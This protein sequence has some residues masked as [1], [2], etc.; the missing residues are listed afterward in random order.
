MEKAKEEQ[1]V[2]SKKRYRIA[3]LIKYI[4]L[5]LLVVLLFLP[6]LQFQ[7]S[8]R[9]FSDTQ[10]KSR[11]SVFQFLIG[12]TETNIEILRESD[13]EEVLASVKVDV[14]A[15]IFGDETASLIGRF[16]IMIG[17]GISWGVLSMFVTDSIFIFGKK[18]NPK[19]Q[20]KLD[21]EYI[22][23]EYELLPRAFSFLEKFIM[24]V[25][26]ATHMLFLPFALIPKYTWRCNIFWPALVIV[27]IIFMNECI[28][29]KIICAKDIRAIKQYGARFDE[30]YERPTI[31][32]DMRE[33]GALF[34]G[35][36][37]TAETKEP[38]AIEMLQRYKSLLDSGVITEEEFAEKKKTLLGINEKDSES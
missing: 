12:D 32:S 37:T 30:T 25:I 21:R 24:G 17:V 29:T 36:R 1:V 35:K 13:S 5:L 33:I 4:Q 19:S 34:A 16:V 31:A 11:F 2:L 6:T 7:L 22:A 27:L 28:L 18:N 26:F 20:V 10:V 8:E 14:A 3:R 23:F 9:L 38:D 15:K